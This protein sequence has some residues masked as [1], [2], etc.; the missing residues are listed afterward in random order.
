LRF[1]V[2]P[3]VTLSRREHMATKRK[4][5]KAKKATRKTRKG[6]KR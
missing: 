2:R 3:A 5:K 4:A 6:K 1:V